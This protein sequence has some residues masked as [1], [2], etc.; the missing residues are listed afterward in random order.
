MLVVQGTP[1]MSTAGQ[2]GDL[3]ASRLLLVIHL[4]VEETP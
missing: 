1:G 2:C 4:N 3:G